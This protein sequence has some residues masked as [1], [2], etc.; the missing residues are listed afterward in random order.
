MSEYVFAK[1]AHYIRHQK[2]LDIIINVSKSTLLT[3]NM[4]IFDLQASFGT[5]DLGK[6]TTLDLSNLKAFGN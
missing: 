2:P 5:L 6:Q 4:V 1:F 3:T